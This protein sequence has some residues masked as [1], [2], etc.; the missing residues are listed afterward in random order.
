MTSDWLAIILLFVLAAATGGAVVAFS[1]AIGR[2]ISPPERQTTYECG[3]NPIDMPRRRF[4][5]KYFLLALV[6]IVLDVEVAFLYPWA[7]AFRGAV[8]QGRGTMLAIEGMIFLA[9]M[10]LALIYVWGRGAMEWEE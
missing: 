3:L 2:R 6:F 4:S 8:G 7:I 5:I 9:V 10:G 1:A